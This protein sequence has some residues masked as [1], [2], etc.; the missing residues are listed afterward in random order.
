MASR[1]SF[2]VQARGRSV[3]IS[4]HRRALITSSK[5]SP[6]VGKLTKC[7]NNVNE[8]FYDAFTYSTVR[9][10]TIKSHGVG[11]VY[12]LAQLSLLF[13]IVGWELI[14]NKGYQA[15]DTVSSVVTTK[16]KGQGFVPINTKR[17][18]SLN[19]SDPLY[20]EKLFSL[21]PNVTYKI[22]DTAGKFKHTK[23]TTLLLCQ[24]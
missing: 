4:Q 18:K 8:F 24:N 15:F 16:V 13:Y 11:I 10:A 1:K 23:K 6:P 12:R 9:S 7:R 21:N 2:S 19:K 14:H 20:Y 22:L 5:N 3:S 17:G